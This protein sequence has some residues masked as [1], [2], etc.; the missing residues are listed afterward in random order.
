MFSHLLLK[1]AH[2]RHDWYTK[3]KPHG[4]LGALVKVLCCVCRD[5]VLIKHVVCGHE[6]YPLSDGDSLGVVVC[7][8]RGLV[9]WSL[10]QRV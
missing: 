9:V 2:H 5:L 4:L 7:V 8:L 3:F 10:L 6:V 1:Y